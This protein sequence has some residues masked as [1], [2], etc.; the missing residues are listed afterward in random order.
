MKIRV[1]LKGKEELKAAF[2]R[3][4]RETRDEI[5]REMIAT[6]LTDIETPAKM[7]LTVKKHVITG[8]LRASLHTAYK[9]KESFNYTDD[10]GQSFNGT[11]TEESIGENDVIVGTN[12][13]YARKIER[14]DPYLFPAFEQVRPKLARRLSKILDKHAKNF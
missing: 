8:R 13:V 6:A 9:G 2:D 10:K 3:F 11:I 1:T 5:K 14:L 12:V 4:K 7:S